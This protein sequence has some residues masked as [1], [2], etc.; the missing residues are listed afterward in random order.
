[1]KTASNLRILLIC[2]SSDPNYQDIVEQARKKASANNQTVEEYD[3][4][5]LTPSDEE[6]FLADIRTIPPQVRGRVKSG[7]ARTLPISNS[8][9]LNRFIPILIFYD[10]PKPVDVYPKDLMGVKY[11]FDSAFK[12]PRVTEVLGV[13]SSIITVLSSRP[14]LLGPELALV[15][16]EFETMSGVVDLVLKDKDGVH[17]FVEV[18]DT[19]DQET[20]GQ[21]LKQSSG[22][23]DKLG[24]TTIR[25]A[26]LT[27]RTSGKVREACRDAGVELYLI[28]AERLP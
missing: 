26:I 18:K 28:S 2:S 27:L 9:R 16:K 6:R 11:D 10:G 25:K 14:E 13:E 23:K 17:V 22:M 8:G 5:N 24:L 21:V 15:D 4:S 20:V 12:T 7:G 19:A 1:M 3:T